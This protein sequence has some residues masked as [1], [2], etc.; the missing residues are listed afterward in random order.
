MPNESESETGVFLKREGPHPLPIL[1]KSALVLRCCCAAAAVQCNLR[2][3]TNLQRPFC[4]TTMATPM[5]LAW[6]DYGSSS[7]V[8]K[9]SL[10]RTPPT[11]NF[12][13]PDTVGQFA[14][15]G[16]RYQ[17]FLY[18]FTNLIS[19]QKWSMYHFQVQRPGGR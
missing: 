8:L 4:T 10:S 3:S 2:P 13:S 15:L 5:C 12:V 7:S 19:A 1:C 6:T 17:F 18:F 16:C 9:L 14:N 11:C